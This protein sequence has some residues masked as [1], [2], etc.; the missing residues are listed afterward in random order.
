MR[1]LERSKLGFVSAIGLSCLLTGAATAQSAV[2]VMHF[3]TSGGE[4][5]ALSEVK[6]AVEAQ[7][8]TWLDAPI[9]GGGG[10]QAITAMKARSTAGNQPA[11]MLMLGY[12][13]KD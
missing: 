2:E 4:A 5:A 12:D 13:I 1:N 6:A 10:E 9:A 7:G 8:V 11:A 3:W